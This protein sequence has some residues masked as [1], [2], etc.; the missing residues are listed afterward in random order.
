M[1]IQEAIVARHS[2][3]AYTDR[4]IEKESVKI[5]TDCIEECNRESGLNI[6]LVLN[7]PKAFD[8]FLAHYGNFSGVR[9]YIAIVGKK[10]KDLQEKA[11][12]Y[13]E[14]I[15]LA[16]QTLG[17]NTCWVAMTYKKVKTAFTVGKGEKLCIV[18][19]LGYGKTQGVPHRSKPFDRVCRIEGTAPEW[20]TDGVKSALLAPTA[21]NQQQFMFTYRDGKAEAKALRGFYSKIDLGIA[22]YHFEVASNHKI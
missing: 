6:Q 3:R 11:G 2:V 16:A 5:L 18:I 4:E 17:L 20:F 13:G 7:E 22:K 19:S 1:T 12:Y 10:T 21:V 8:C 15:V 9:N 14:R